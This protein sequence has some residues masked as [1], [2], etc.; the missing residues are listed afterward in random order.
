MTKIRG[1][2]SFA[3]EDNPVWITTPQDVDRFIDGLLGEPFENS[4]AALYVDGRTNEK[5]FT[6]H[7]L[8]VAVNGRDQVGGLRYLGDAGSFYAVG[9]RSRYEELTYYYMG[10]DRPF[11]Q[12]SELSLELIRQGVKDFLASGGDRPSVGQWEV[13]PDEVG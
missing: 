1:Y 13:W 9:E 7:E 12:D 10:S 11:P 2:F 3:H 4:V 8:L 5:G 6:D